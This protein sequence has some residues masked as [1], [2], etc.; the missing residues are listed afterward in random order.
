MERSNSLKLK[1]VVEKVMESK[2]LNNPVNLQILNNIINSSPNLIIE[3]LNKLEIDDPTINKLK[4]PLKKLIDSNEE[5]KNY[6]C[7]KESDV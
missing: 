4:E 3:T 1:N 5:L 2:T 7:N 6:I